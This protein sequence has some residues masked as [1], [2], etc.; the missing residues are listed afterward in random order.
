MMRSNDESGA[1]DRR[2]LL[3]EQLRLVGA[4][5]NSAMAQVYAMTSAKVNG[6][7]LRMTGDSSVAEELLQD[8]YLSVWRR[9][10]TFDP[11]RASPMTWLISIARNRA[12]DHLRAQRSRG[13][14]APHVELQDVIDTSPSVL[15]AQMEAEE[16][17]QLLRCLAGL[18][19][20]QQAA[21][22]AAFFDGYTY[23]MLA[24]RAGV[25][26]GTMKSWIRRGLLRLGA[27]LREEPRP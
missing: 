11:A 1:D 5:D 10:T 9:V 23:E 16:Q 27:C 7:L 13:S 24:T 26:I 25:P 19:A 18:E 8:V 20:R 4:G 22:R 3:V 15:E 17:H 21:I 6:V 14:T 12:I 2:S